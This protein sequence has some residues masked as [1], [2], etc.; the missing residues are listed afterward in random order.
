MSCAEFDRRSNG[1]I[2]RAALVRFFLLHEVPNPPLCESN[3]ADPY[4]VAARFHIPVRPPPHFHCER[5]AA[6][7]QATPA[8]PTYCYGSPTLACRAAFQDALQ[9]VD[10]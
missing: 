3:R 7:R 9:A 1:D 8:A 2:V 6:I 10:R 5:A 4:E